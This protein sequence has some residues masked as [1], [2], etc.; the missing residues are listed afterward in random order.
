MSSQVSQTSLVHQVTNSFLHPIVE[1]LKEIYETPAESLLETTPPGSIFEDMSNS[2][3]KRDRS[4]A[5][6]QGIEDVSEIETLNLD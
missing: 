4:S 6:R 3:A 2:T 5:K 1:D